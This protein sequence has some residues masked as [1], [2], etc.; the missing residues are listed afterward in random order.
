[1]A[2]PLSS[3]DSGEVSRR[4]R[5]KN[6]A[7]QTSSGLGPVELVVLTFPGT[8]VDA[9]VTAALAEIVG[10]GTV[11]LLDL[12]VLRRDEAGVITEFEIDDDVERLGLSGLTAADID[13]VG[14]ADLEVVRASMAP[15]TTAVIVVFEE[16]WARE[17]AGAVRAA[18]GEVAL[19]VQVPRDAVE[20]AVAAVS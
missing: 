8:R 3:P 11:T 17:L 6:R 10:R 15:G 19:H 16:T 7:M 20:A 18:R 12:V 5:A 14:E 9:T 13:L 2:E 4:P 1:M